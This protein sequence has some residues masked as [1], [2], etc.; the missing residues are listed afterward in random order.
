[1]KN[2]SAIVRKELLTIF[3]WNWSKGLQ[4]IV[5]ELNNIAAQILKQ[6]KKLSVT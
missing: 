4:K 3:V 2:A 5:W 6:L 1:M